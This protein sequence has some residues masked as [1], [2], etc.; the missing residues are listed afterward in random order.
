MPV[1][2]WCWR[3]RVCVAGRLPLVRCDDFFPC[4]G[5]MWPCCSSGAELVGADCGVIRP[6]AAGARQILRRIGVRDPGSRSGNSRNRL[7]RRVGTR[8]HGTR[9]GATRPSWP[10]IGSHGDRPRV[11]RPR[12]HVAGAAGV[13]PR[14]VDSATHAAALRGLGGRV[15]RPPGRAAD[16]ARS[17][18]WRGSPAMSGCSSCCGRRSRSTTGSRGSPTAR[19][20]ARN[21]A[22]SRPGRTPSASSILPF[23]VIYAAWGLI[24]EDGIAYS[25]SALDQSDLDGDGGTALDTPFTL[26]TISIVVGAFVLRRLIARFSAR[27][28]ALVRRDRRLPRGGLGVHRPLVH[29]GPSRVGSGLARHPAHVR[30]GRRWLGA[31]ARL[32]PAAAMARGRDRVDRRPA[33]RGHLPAPGLARSRGDRS[34]RRAPAGEACAAVA[35][36]RDSSGGGAALVTAG[37]AY[38]PLLDLALGRSARTLAAD[39]DRV[40]TDLA[41]RTRDDGHLRPRIRRFGRRRRL[42][43]RRR[44]SPARA[45]RS[46]WWR[47]WEHPLG[48]LFDVVVFPLQVCLVAAAFDRC[49]RAVELAEGGEPVIAPEADTAGRTRR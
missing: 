29:Q 2:S 40:A 31:A 11:P 5:R 37:T 4:S 17:P 32:G 39:R 44:L 15:H 18:C 8:S 1:S 41:R 7:G 23:F 3:R 19:R 36:R 26:A 16:R 25:L 34:R 6:S 43:L 14:R 10:R 38:P 13:V 28:P 20:R 22:S 21:R 46:R 30:L 45:A 42:D 12:P 9:T 49:L 33:G 27:L 35:F 24:A 48:L 47:A